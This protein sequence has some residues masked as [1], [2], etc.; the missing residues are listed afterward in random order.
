MHHQHRQ[1]A[2]LGIAVLDLADRVRETIGR[3]AGQD[4]DRGAGVVETIIIVAG[5]AILAA[6]IYAAVGGRVHAWIAKIP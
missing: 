5:F 6:A 4:R 1:P 2:R 3:R